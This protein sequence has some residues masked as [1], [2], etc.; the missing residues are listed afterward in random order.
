MFL[1]VIETQ[2]EIVYTN[3]IKL[4]RILATSNYKNFEIKSNWPILIIIFY[5]CLTKLNKIFILSINANIK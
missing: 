3:C 2:K 5:Y 4:Y 1:I